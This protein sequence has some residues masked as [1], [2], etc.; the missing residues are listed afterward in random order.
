MQL[1][2]ALDPTPLVSRMA[3]FLLWPSYVYPQ[4]IEIHFGRLNRMTVTSEEL[5]PNT[6]QLLSEV[7]FR[8]ET[9]LERVFF[10]RIA[11]SVGVL[12]RNLKD[13]V[14]SGSKHS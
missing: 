13:K 14:A 2:A 4:L 3:K 12:L 7:S 10:R 5:E 6:F 9:H 8:I 1:A 11:R